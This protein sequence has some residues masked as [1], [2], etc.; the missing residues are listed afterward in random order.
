MLTNKDGTPRER[1]QCPCGSGESKRDNRDGHGIPLPSTCS[2]CE[3]RVLG[4]Y[5]ADIFESYDC[6]EP[7]ESDG[8]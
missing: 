2:K 7:I 4:V 6:D 1:W 8:W 5:R 3:S